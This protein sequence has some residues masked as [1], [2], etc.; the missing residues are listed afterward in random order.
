VIDPVISLSRLKENV[1]PAHE[2]GQN[3]ARQRLM[4][5]ISVEAAAEH[6]ER[7]AAGRKQSRR[8]ESF[9]SGLVLPDRSSRLRA[10]GALAVALMALTFVAN[11]VSPPA[12]A[13]ADAVTARSRAEADAS[14]ALMAKVAAQNE[15]PHHRRR[16]SASQAPITPVIIFPPAQ[17]VVPDTTPESSPDADDRQVPEQSEEPVETVP[18]EKDESP[19]GGE[20]EPAGDDDEPTGDDD[21]PTQDDPSSGEAPAAPDTGEKTQ[22]GESGSAGSSGDASQTAL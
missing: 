7:P 4:Q 9:W 20:D 22:P 15:K 21:E 3:V 10:A 16:R 11:E 13:D 8:D 18:G 12:S 19:A 5:A 17:T 14:L 1:A 2:T 6:T